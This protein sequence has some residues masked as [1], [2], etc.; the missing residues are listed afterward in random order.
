MES[1]Q[2]VHHRSP[3]ALQVCVSLL[4]H[5]SLNDFMCG[6]GWWLTIFRPSLAER[7]LT[8][9]TA[10]LQIHPAPQPLRC[11][12]LGVGCGQG[13][14]LQAANAA[15]LG[16]FDGRWGGKDGALYRI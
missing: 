11:G 10:G 9:A 3:C 6:K 15:C 14:K 2:N 8:Q 13:A 5:L 16:A 12:G 7:S 4:L 1:D